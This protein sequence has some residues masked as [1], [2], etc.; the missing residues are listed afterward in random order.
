M[1]FPRELRLM[2]VFIALAAG[3]FAQTLILTPSTT[4]L[5]SAGGTVTFTAAISYPSPVSTLGFS[6]TLP[7]G[8]SY[9]SG[10]TVAGTLPAEPAIAPSAGRTGLLEWAFIDPPIGTATFTFTAAY[11]AGTSG[12]QS[13][14]PNLLLRTST[15]TPPTTVTPPTL[16]LP[17]AST[18]LV[19]NNGTGVWTDATQWSPNTVPANTG[20]SR[21]SAT[22]SA[23]IAS[24]NTNV[25]IDNLTFTGGTINGIGN[26]TLTSISSTWAAGILA[27]SG[28]LII[29]PGAALTASGANPHTYNEKTVR[30]FGTFKWND[31]GTLQSA[32]AGKFFNSAGATFIDATTGAPEALLAGSTGG[33]FT[34]AGTYLKTTASLTRVSTPFI[35]TGSLLVNAGVMRFT[36]S[37][38]QTSGG[39][40][41]AAGA[42]A[43]F[44]LGLNF[45]SG[46]LIGGGTINGDLANQ[47][48]ISP[49][50]ILGT[51]TVN[52]KLSLLSTSVLAFD[53]GGTSPGVG[54]DFLLVN[55]TVTF[56]GTLQLNVVNGVRTSLLPTDTFTLLSATS[57]TGAFANVAS[58]TRLMSYTGEGS[59]LVTYNGSNLVLSNFDPI[60]EPST[61]ALF[62]SGLATLAVTAY[63]RS[64]QR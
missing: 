39:L 1:V 63:R 2:S 50:N 19:W 36:D 61:W 7:T 49:G 28:E 9:L 40:V 10:T 60:P 17:P 14:T 16:A 53:I 42:T 43:T 44:D 8:W 29:A 51:L 22:V 55:N 41:V 54:Y 24:L 45:T 3:T 30:N 27:G 64:R 57:V 52:G 35:N 58:G 34:N 47:G 38:T 20:S 11:A 23:G 12:S 48:F 33:N 25:E 59:F 5:N 32:L 37:F 4:L 56:G 31:S 13:V 15:G 6:L 26:L 46:A 21:F 18:F 62:I